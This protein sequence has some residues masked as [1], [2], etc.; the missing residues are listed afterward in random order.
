VANDK[1][2][3]RRATKGDLPAIVELWKE[4]MD[5][6]SRHDPILTRS[7]EGHERFAEYLGERLD[8][9]EAIVVVAEVGGELVGYCLGAVDHRPAVFDRREYGSVKDLAVTEAYRRQ[10][11]GVH[12]FEA[13]REWFRERGLDR[14][15]LLVATE[16][17]AANA[18][19][20]RLGFRPYLERLFIDL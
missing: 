7:A 3:I 19:W 13:V 16:N 15:E 9:P 10:R 4:F 11:I 1:V 2:V 18:F 5:F 8:D 12:L 17:P 20:H 14:V 6:H